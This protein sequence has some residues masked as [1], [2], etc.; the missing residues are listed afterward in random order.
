M[1]KDMKITGNSRELS[2]SPLR[3]L[4]WE[5]DRTGCN[6]VSDSH[7]HPWWLLDSRI[8]NNSLALKKS[9]P[10]SCCELMCNPVFKSFLTSIISWCARA[11]IF[12]LLMWLKDSAMSWPKVYPAPLGFMPQPDLSSGSDHKRSHMGPSCGTSWIL[13]SDLMLSRVSIDG[14]RPPWRQKK[15][16]ST[17]AVSGR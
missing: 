5:Q 7:P 6:S 3:F 13:L 17:T 9:L 1:P 2:F 14:E 15:E 11:I 10:H 8:C 12:R 16:F 4:F